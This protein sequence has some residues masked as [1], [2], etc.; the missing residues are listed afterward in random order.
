MGGPLNIDLSVEA[1]GPNLTGIGR[2][3]WNLVQGLS[4]SADIEQLRYFYQNRWVETPS[5]LLEHEPWRPPRWK[6]WLDRGRHFVAR[7]GRTP[8]PLFHGPNFFLPEFVEGGVI[9]IHDLSVFKFPETHPI[10]RIREFERRFL[11]SVGRAAHII[12]D[13][14]TVR[15]EVIAYLS[16]SPDRVT[17]VHLG[18][19]LEYF[20]REREACDA[21][22]PKYD[23][24]WK[25]Y[26]LC[27]ATLEPRKKIGAAV[28]AYWALPVSVRA[29]YSLVVVGAMGWKNADL[30]RQ[31][32]QS[33]SQGA[34]RYL[35][36]VEERDLPAIYDGARLFLYP[37]IYEGFGL[38]PIEAMASGVPVIVSSSSCLPEVTNGAAMQVEP[39]SISGFA[40][41]IEK[42]LEDEAWRE[43]AIARGIEVSSGYR[44]DRCVE[45]TI[46]VYKR[47]LGAPARLSNLSAASAH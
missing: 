15:E 34:V 4:T 36:F 44:W 14:E 30:G 11:S 9:T 19:G 27:V 40:E 46:D 8:A 17:A 18:V 6:R 2:Y 28:E 29:R 20:P 38:P 41:A 45:N 32:E 47:V 3:T 31:L 13:T 35:G 12:T 42:A 26:I 7:A 16:L 1:L 43:S 33:R 22:M 25:S 5:R 21:V 24:A 10:E 39:D 37:S 23:L